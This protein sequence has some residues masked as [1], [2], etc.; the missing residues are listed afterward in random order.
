MFKYK[1]ANKSYPYKKMEICDDIVTNTQL[2]F[3]LGTI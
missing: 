2:Y 3:A 1:T